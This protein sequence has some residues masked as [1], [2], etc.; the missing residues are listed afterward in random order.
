M[1]K[2]KLLIIENHSNLRRSLKNILQQRVRGLDIFESQSI[3][4]ARFQILDNPPDVILINIK[5]AGDSGL[6]FAKKILDI[7]PEIPILIISGWNIFEYCQIN[8]A[9]RQRV[10]ILTN[11]FDI[12][13][14]VNMLKSV[15]QN[16]KKTYPNSGKF[17]DLPEKISLY[18][19]LDYAFT[20]KARRKHSF[21]KC[22]V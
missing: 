21:N 16:R 2:C 14:I 5:V 19:N 3:N 17:I 18:G 22:Y 11:N 12:D 8:K 6:L 20:L 4:D 1:S 15:K 9:I 13:K 10:H 7:S